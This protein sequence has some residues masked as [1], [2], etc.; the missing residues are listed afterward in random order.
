MDAPKRAKKSKKQRKVGRNAVFCKY[1]AT[2]RKRESNKLIRLNR[3]LSR[4]P[5]DLC[6]ST[7]AKLAASIV[8]A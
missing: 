4:F 2:S 5:D 6:A 8:G 1:Y 3:H 7:A